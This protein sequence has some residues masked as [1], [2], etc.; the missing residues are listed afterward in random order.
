MVVGNCCLAGLRPCLVQR[1]GSW[2]PCCDANP[3]VNYDRKRPSVLASDLYYAGEPIDFISGQH[4]PRREM[5]RHPVFPRMEGDD[6]P[7]VVRF[8]MDHTVAGDIK[9]QRTKIEG[10]PVFHVVEVEVASQCRRPI[11]LD[12]K[13][14]G[15]AEDES[16]ASNLRRRIRK[17][18]DTRMPVLDKLV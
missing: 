9:L 13:H 16:L 12:Q 1:W 3:R 10:K 2:D 18:D 4:V 17:N 6:S 7:M 11:V 14:R 5:H 8:Y 15:L